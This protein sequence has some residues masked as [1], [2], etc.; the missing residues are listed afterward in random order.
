M[1]PKPLSAFEQ[2]MLGKRTLIESVNDQL[3]HICQ[4]AHTRHRSVCNFVVNWLQD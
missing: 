2:Q 4:I 3:K 1:K